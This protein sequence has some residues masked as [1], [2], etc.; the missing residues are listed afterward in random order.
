MG[1]L[2]QP[3]HGVRKRSA[4][5]YFS[6]DGDRLK[7]HS[8]T[9]DYREISFQERWTDG[10]TEFRDVR[11]ADGRLTVEFDIDEWRRGAGPL[12]VDAGKAPQQTTVRIEARLERDGRL[13]GKWG[14][15]TA[16]GF[17]VF[18][19]E[20][21]AIRNPEP[22]GKASQG[23]PPAAGAGEV[24][25]DQVPGSVHHRVIKNDW[26]RVAGLVKVIDARTLEYAD[27]TRIELGY[28]TPAIDQLAQRSGEFYP[29]GR[30]AADFVRRLIGDRPVRCSAPASERPPGPW[31]A[32]VG[33]TNLE[34]A[35]VVNGWA[36]AN[37][38][39]LQADEVI[40]REQQRGLWR[41]DFIKP[42]DWQAGVRLAG[43]V[44]PPRLAGER[45]ANRLISQFGRT[46]AA[47]EELVARIRADLPNIRRLDFAFSRIDDELLVRLT[48]L[49][50][51]AALD[52][53]QTRIT[54][55]GLVHVG[56]IA[57][58]EFLDVSETAVTDAGMDPLLRL[59]RLKI[60]KVPETVSQTARIRLR[61]AIPGIR[62]E[63]KA[64][65]VEPAN[66]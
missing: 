26:M 12:A 29:A 59:M 38:S 14:M 37:H 2:Y 1:S 65:E 25:R 55:A 60:L 8:L 18:R 58:L 56:K 30:E 20:W 64:D 10:R 9:P 23:T 49:P 57:S 15:F 62:F 52:L 17:E 54:D 11:F 16:D 33:D 44:P 7:G 32:Y 3:V 28:V 19:G 40:A 31:V 66:R 51:L 4:T 13:V 39:S 36:L 63:G 47:I 48:G 46:D 45:E 35:L 22:G 27:G 61:E 21:E 53:H 41:G 6:L 50:S 34:R 42:W 43:E 5:I 24:I